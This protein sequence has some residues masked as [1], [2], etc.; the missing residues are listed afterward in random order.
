LKTWRNTG[1]QVFGGLRLRQ[2]AS[3]LWS[4]PSL[5]TMRRKRG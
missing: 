5:V 4:L 3:D 1:E 2:N